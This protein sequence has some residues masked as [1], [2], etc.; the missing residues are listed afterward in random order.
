LSYPPWPQANSLQRAG[1]TV[2][3]QLGFLLFLIPSDCSAW[4]ESFPET[5][6]NRVL[7]HPPVK[8]G[9]SALLPVSALGWKTA[10]TC[11]LYAYSLLIKG[12]DRWLGT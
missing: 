6:D 7:K 11:T 5:L 1:I 8:V 4:P 9:R 10:L 12:N 2:D 3:H